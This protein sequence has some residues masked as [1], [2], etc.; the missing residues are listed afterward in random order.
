MLMLGPVHDEHNFKWVE[1][2]LLPC[3][4]VQKTTL[5]VLP[6]AA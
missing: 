6:T 3:V 2:L 5:V 1:K 4:T